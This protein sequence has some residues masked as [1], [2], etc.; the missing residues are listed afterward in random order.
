MVVLG[1]GAMV[2]AVV[3]SE[4][5]FVHPLVHV[6]A[7]V[8]PCVVGAACV[9]RRPGRFQ[10]GVAGRWS[11][12][13]LRQLLRVTLRHLVHHFRLLTQSIC[14]VPPLGRLRLSTASFDVRTSRLALHGRRALCTCCSRSALLSL[15]PPPHAASHSK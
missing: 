1:V 8:C 15:P 7:T 2:G 13:I 4:M 3:G 5:Q 9:A 12:W 11:L 6:L 10:R 14:C